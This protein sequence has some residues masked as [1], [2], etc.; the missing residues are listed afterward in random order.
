MSV[1][2]TLS[3]FVP[4][5]VTE[6]N[7]RA[8]GIVCMSVILAGCVMA[9][10][11]GT[12]DLLEDR[13]E[14]SAVLP[15]SAGLDSGSLVRVA[16]VEVGEVTGLH[17]D[18]DLGQVVVTFEVEDHIKL[19]RDEARADVALSTLLGGEYI[20]LSGV[21]GGG[22][23]LRDL[24]R[25]ERRI[26]IQRTS[27]PFSVNEAF[28]EA[29]DVVQ[30][31]DTD[32]LNDLVR[33]FADI[34]TD[35]GPRVERVLSGLEDVARAFNEREGAIRRLLDQSQ[36]LTE[37][38]AEKD[39]TL[40]R[41]I[42]AANVVLD[43]ISNRREELAAVFGDGSDVVQRL[44]DILESK[45]AE[46]DQ[47]L[48]DLDLATDLVDRQQENVDT[49]LAWSGPTYWQVSRITSHGPWID[50]LPISLGPS[51]PDTLNRLYPQ[52]GLEGGG[53]G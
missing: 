36:I 34:A 25:D 26:P 27:V 31:V 7:K 40:V 17:A 51:V 44:A 23:Y 4:P 42:D 32:T 28:T 45:R 13:Y 41:L 1:R 33:E 47:I 39:Q 43:E 20:R 15:E 2:D 30:A 10:A 19:N 37:T 29:T 14:V 8:V 9:F 49:I 50:A 12:L 38:L 16:G 3:R 21:G 18:R 24:P 22:P 11:V 5:P 48:N 53:S 46:L 52:L 35:S 6:M